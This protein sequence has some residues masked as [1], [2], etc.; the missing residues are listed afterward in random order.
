MLRRKAEKRDVEKFHAF[1]QEYSRLFEIC[2][3][4]L[5]FYLDNDIIRSIVT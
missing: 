2:C 4:K 5:N 3:K 1:S